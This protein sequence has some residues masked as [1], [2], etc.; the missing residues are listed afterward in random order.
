MKKIYLMSFIIS[1]FVFMPSAFAQCPPDVSGTWYYKGVDVTECCSDPSNNGTHIKS[2]SFVV[3]QVGNEISATWINS[4]G[5]T[6][7]L[8]GTVNGKSVY[9]KVEFPV[10][11]GDVKHFVGIIKGNRVNGFATGVDFCAS[12]KWHTKG[13]FKIV[14]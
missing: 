9:F 8:T 13:N 5:D 6:Q 4:D 1:A 7:V 11:E 12:C 14:K 10:C 2:G 3:A